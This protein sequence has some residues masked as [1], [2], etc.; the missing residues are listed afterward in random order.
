M[1]VFDQ[2]AA[3]PGQAGGVTHFGFRLLSAADIDRAGGKILRRGEFSPGIPH[4][5]VT[6]PD[7]YQIEIWF[8]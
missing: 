3:H 5:Y 2:N 8:E 1:I 7:G 6:D 4:V